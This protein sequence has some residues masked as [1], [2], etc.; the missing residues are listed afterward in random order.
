MW[1]GDSYRIDEASGWW[2]N[3]ENEAWQYDPTSGIF[4]N[5][6][7]GQFYRQNAATQQLEPVA[8]EATGMFVPRSALTAWGTMVG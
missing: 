5:A 1:C 6:L 7:D 3:E 8:T 4:Y 2:V